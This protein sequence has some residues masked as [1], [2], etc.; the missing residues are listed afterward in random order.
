[1]ADK[2]HSVT[3]DGK[4]Y[5]FRT[6]NPEHKRLLKSY[7]RLSA[8]RQACGVGLGVSLFLFPSVALLQG[9]SFVARLLMGPNGPGLREN[10]ASYSRTYKNLGATCALLIIGGIASSVAR[11]KVLQKL[12]V[13]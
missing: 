3:M 4:I 9:G 7:R 11:R 6:Q 10:E 1:M 2:D 5:T 13:K 12:H 8:S